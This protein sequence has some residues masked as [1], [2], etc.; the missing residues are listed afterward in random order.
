MEL[1]VVSVPRRDLRWIKPRGAR[2][3]HSGG[4]N[5]LQSTSFAARPGRSVPAGQ[6]GERG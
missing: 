6:P 4:M 1:I 2:A 3:D 5:S